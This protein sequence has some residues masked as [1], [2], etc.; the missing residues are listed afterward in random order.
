MQ[1][2]SVALE[3]TS[4]DEW[5][6]IDITK[7]VIILETIK[8]VNFLNNLKHIISTFGYSFGETKSFQENLGVFK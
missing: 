1:K 5:R 2:N 6:I 4:H 7:D 8:A 3:F